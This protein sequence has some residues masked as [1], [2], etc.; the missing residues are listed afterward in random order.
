MKRKN[1]EE[2][3]RRQIGRGEAHGIKAHNMVEIDYINKDLFSTH[4]VPG[5]I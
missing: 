2:Y 5:T 1:L 4:Y 3:I